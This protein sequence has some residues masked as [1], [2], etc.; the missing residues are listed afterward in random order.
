MLYLDS[1]A[2]PDEDAESGFI[3]S[4]PKQFEMACYDQNNAYPFKIFPQKEMPRL[5]FD[6]ITIF[7]GGNGSGKSTLLNVI[8]E[9]L[10]LT[11]K[12][13]FNVTPLYRDYLRLCRAELH[14]GHRVPNESKIITSDAVFDF[15]L[16]LRALNQG[17][18]RRREELFDSYDKANDPNSRFL[19]SGLSEFEEFREFHHTRRVTKS[20][21]TA[22]RLPKNL[23][24]KSNGESAFAYFTE[25]ITDHAL[26]LLDEPENSLSAKLQAELAQF[27]LDSARFYDCQFVIATHSP[28]LLGIR[29]AKVYDLDTV[30]VRERPWT[31]L[32][33][34]RTYY[35]FFSSH[36][37]EF[38]K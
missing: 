34:V 7:Y 6:P 14:F 4:Y 5:T 37:K 2:L 10:E 13:P 21:Y 31:E 26:Y 12:A 36:A 38:E 28:F 22:R 29:E 32:D 27:L 30:P 17:I 20:Q 23:V 8:A 16:D 9:K 15:L 25:Q 33:A 3:L 1:F 24:G 19:L 35:D 11:R 18:D